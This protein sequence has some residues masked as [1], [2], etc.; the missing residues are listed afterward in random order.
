VK[1]LGTGEVT[2]AF[3]RL[4]G[5]AV[6]AKREGSDREGR[7]RLSK[8]CLTSFF[9]KVNLVFTR[10]RDTQSVLFVLG[11]LVVFRLPRGDPDPGRRS[12]RARE[13]LS[14]Q[15]VLRP[16]ERLLGRRLSKLSI[17]MLG[18]G[19]YI[20]ASII[21]QLATII[22]PKVKACTPRKGEAG[23]RK[24]INWS[25]I[26]TIP[27]AVLQSIGFLYL[28]PVA[29]AS[30]RTSR[31]SPSS[32]ISCSIAAGSM[33]L[34][35]IGELVTEFGIGN[36]V[37]LIIFAGIAC[38]HPVGHLAGALHRERGEYP[39]VL[40]FACAR[41]RLHLRGG[42]RLRGRAFDPDRVR[43][44]RCAAQRCRRA[45]RPISR[46]ASCRPA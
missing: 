30:S 20:T 3:V 46:S 40:G 8:P 33:L 31:P 45:Q 32:R 24:F 28:S 34:M 11:A 5:V 44:R 2:K 38:A 37:S 18:V 4:K 41:P 16:L 7:R 14:E 27:L 9:H 23:A 42:R 36:G 19:P 12:Q 25:R 21:M 26:L 29:R 15:P 6:S 35:W 10:S 17:V 13:L 39:G 22:F 43:A 1:I